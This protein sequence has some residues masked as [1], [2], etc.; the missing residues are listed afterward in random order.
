MNSG[1]AVK[2]NLGSATMVIQVQVLAQQEKE[3]TFIEAG[4]EVGQATVNIEYIFF[5]SS[6]ES[7]AGK[8]RNISS[9][10]WSPP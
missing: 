6:A 2:S 7:L 9:S 3:N 4:K 1:S 8:K 5:F 10:Y